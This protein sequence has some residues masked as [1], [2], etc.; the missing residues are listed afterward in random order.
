M[1]E[2]EKDK[3]NLKK[4][5]IDLLRIAE[6]NLLAS[7]YGIKPEELLKQITPETNH[8]CWIFGHCASQLDFIF[9]GLCQ[10]KQFFSDEEREYYSYGVSKEK[11]KNPPPKSFMQ[12]V[13][14]YLEI[15]EDAFNYLNKL[16]EEK[17]RET[18]EKDT[19]KNTKES[20]IQ[21]I[22]RVALHFLGHMGQITLIRVALGNPMGGFVGGIVEKNREGLYE[23]WNKWWKENKELYK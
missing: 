4:T 3:R 6:S 21:T 8:I 12:V 19:G 2:L 7:I 23:R 18:L 9:A 1:I 22:D 11:A 15:S 10:G 20:L 17:F 16:P 5:K 13:N 14:R